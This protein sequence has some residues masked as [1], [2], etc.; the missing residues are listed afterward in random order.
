MLSGFDSSCER[1]GEVS[2]LS[3]ET[4]SCIFIVE[5]PIGPRSG[6]IW[7]DAFFPWQLT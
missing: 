6:S 7:T 5:A 2:G 4:L 1:E 3:N